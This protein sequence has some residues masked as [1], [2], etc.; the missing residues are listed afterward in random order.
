MFFCAAVQPETRPPAHGR[1]R[2]A[3]ALTAILL[4][5]ALYFGPGW[6]FRHFLGSAA[7]AGDNGPEFT[8]EKAGGSLFSRSAYVENFCLVRLNGAPLA[9]PVC[10]DSVRAEG[11]CLISLFKL[12]REDGG[13]GRTRALPLARSLAAAG[14][15]T[16]GGPMALRLDEAVL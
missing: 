6:V 4:V 1:L 16:G 2:R 11:V 9:A 3:L 15:K 8:F 12:W 13:Q 5:L 14:L 10:F 7:L